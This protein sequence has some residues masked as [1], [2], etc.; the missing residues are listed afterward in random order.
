MDNEKDMI[1]QELMSGY[2]HNGFVTLVEGYEASTKVDATNIIEL[3]RQLVNKLND[4]AKKS[5]RK[6]MNNK[7]KKLNT[8]Q[9]KGTSNSDGDVRK[10][11]KLVAELQQTVVKYDIDKHRN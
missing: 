5:F 11:R 8:H 4:N 2:D 9:S 7:I 3:A 10:F 6:E 1:L